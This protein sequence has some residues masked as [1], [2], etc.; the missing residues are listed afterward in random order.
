[1]EKRQ[2]DS[3]IIGKARR[4]ANDENGLTIHLE[5]NM[6]N[7]VDRSHIFFSVVKD[8]NQYG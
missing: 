1:M 2:K 6:I 5:K 8:I 4:L 3:P 7:A